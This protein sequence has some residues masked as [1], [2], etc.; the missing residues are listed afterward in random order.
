MPQ[1]NNKKPPAGSPQKWDPWQVFL[2]D[3]PGFKNNSYWTCQHPIRR[4]RR[5]CDARI[6]R[7]EIVRIMNEMALQDPADVSLGDLRRLATLFFC[8]HIHTIASRVDERARGLQMSLSEAFLE[9]EGD[10]DEV[11]GLADK[12]QAGM[13]I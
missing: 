12:F 13:G 10:E 8:R 9:E 2:H 3:L 6:N 5:L 1:P 11:A 4:Q 7:P